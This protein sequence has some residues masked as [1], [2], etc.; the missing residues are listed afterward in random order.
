MSETG[1]VDAWPKRCKCGLS[2]DEHTWKCLEYVGVHE[3][4]AVSLELRNC[5]CGSTLAQEIERG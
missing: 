5:A 4:D 1:L 3:D 2:Y